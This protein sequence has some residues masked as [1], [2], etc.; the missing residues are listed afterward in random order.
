MSVES[1]VR[2]RGL[3]RRAQRLFSEEGSL[4]VLLSV[5]TLVLGVM[6]A[7]RPDTWPFTSLVVPLTI[8]SVVIGPR[9]LPWFVILVLAVLTVAVAQQTEITPRI[10]SSVGVIF[11]VGLII[12]LASFRRTRLGV[13]GV[14]GESMFVD[15]RDRILRQGRLPALPPGWYVESALRSAS[16]TP[17][18]GDLVL[19]ARRGHVVDLVVADVSG[20]GEGVGTKSLLLSGALAGL[21]S[22][23]P[24]KEFLPAA[25]RYLL[26]QE[27]AEGFATCV[28]LVVD[29]GTGAFE[30]RSA[31]H[32]PAIQVHAGT[33]TVST[34][35]PE[36][37][38]LGLL[39]EAEFE[40]LVGEL[41]PGDAV[42]LYT[43]GMVEAPGQDLALGID[44]LAE[45]AE[46]L[47]DS[48]LTHGAQRLVDELGSADDDRA[49]VL[50]HRL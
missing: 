39:E 6:C 40:P 29:L 20:K 14:Q 50:V 3:A 1:R 49:L 10:A 23:I 46:R 19:A 25:N 31:G 17:F 26:R 9:R 4:V 18:A 13:A 42:L 22:E 33:G 45:K 27:W 5:A 48:G 11:V 24:S 34:L 16:G 15:L 7:L 2:R 12:M 35:Q 47:L 44:R 21:L 8:G 43:D 41:E 32:P 30:V 37:P 36:G 28:H 38:L